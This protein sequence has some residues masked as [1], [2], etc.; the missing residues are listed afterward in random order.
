M[1]IKVIL[2]ILAI[3]LLTLGPGL[4]GQD[5]QSKK[6]TKQQQA[7]RPSGEE[8]V[9]GCLTKQQ[10]SFMIATP[11]GEQLSV[12]GSPDL[13]KHAGHTVKL[14][15]SKSDEGG[16]KT[17]TVNKIEHVSASCSK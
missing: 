12:T 3:G 14:T 6:D 17:L 10:D 1:K 8:T 2:S 15:G 13:S 11:T 7:D 9:T 4:Y 5:D 16:K